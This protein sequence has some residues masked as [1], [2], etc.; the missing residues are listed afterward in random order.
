MN[1]RGIKGR[2]CTSERPSH[3]SRVAAQC[4]IKDD[5]QSDEPPRSYKLS[6]IFVLSAS[7]EDGI[8]R[9]KDA[10][11]GCISTSIIDGAADHPD[12]LD[13]VAFTLSNKRSSLP[14]KAFAVAQTALGLCQGLTFKNSKPNRSSVSPLISFIFTGQGS[15]WAGMGLELLRYPIFE[16]SLRRSSTYLESLGCEWTLMSSSL[17]SSVKL[18]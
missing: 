2:H 13:N 3:L 14:W 16:A 8:R 5:I 10:Y 1:E 15:Q 9:L 7:D 4:Q 12:Y 11:E 17:H 6:K 18:R